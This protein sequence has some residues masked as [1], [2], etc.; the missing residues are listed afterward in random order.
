MYRAV[1]VWLALRRG[2]VSKGPREAVDPYQGEASEANECVGPHAHLDHEK[3][4]I[5]TFGSKEQQNNTNNTT[6][7]IATF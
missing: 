1:V 6:T 4:V 3:S 7:K 2:E 5:I